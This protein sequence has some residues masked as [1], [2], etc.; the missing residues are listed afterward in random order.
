MFGEEVEDKMEEVEGRFDRT[1][2][3]IT[4]SGEQKQPAAACGGGGG[5]GGGGSTVVAVNGFSPHPRPRPP[6]PVTPADLRERLSAMRRWFHQFDSNQRTL[7]L[8]AIMVRLP[9]G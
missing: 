7:A 4:L 2:T 1:T 8:Q 6:P 3:R 5:G 9:I